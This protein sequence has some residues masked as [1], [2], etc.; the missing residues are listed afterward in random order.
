MTHASVV[1]SE[2]GYSN[3]Q[4]HVGDGTLG[5][6]EFSPFER[7]MVTA[8]APSVPQSLLDQLGD[9]GRLVIPVGGRFGQYLELNYQGTD[10]LAVST[11]ITLTQYIESLEFMDFNM[12]V[13][14]PDFK[15]KKR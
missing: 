6:P 15:A 9:G 3:I 14:R 8:A 5:L 10:R 13:S 1:F 4:I 2:L 11:K 7:I 12:L